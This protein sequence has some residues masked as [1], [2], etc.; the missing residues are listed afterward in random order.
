MT[1]IKKSHKIK[2]LKNKTKIYGD[3]RYQN[4]I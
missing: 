2:I 1:C 3:L 4:E